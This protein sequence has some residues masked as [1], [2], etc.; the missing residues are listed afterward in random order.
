MLST[1]G[2]IPPDMDMSLDMDMDVEQD[3]V[4]MDDM[5]IEMNSSFRGSTS[6]QTVGGGEVEGGSPAPPYH[7]LEMG[8][9]AAKPPSDEGG[10]SRIRVDIEK[11][12]R[13]I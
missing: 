4:E 13:T 12:T 9:K 1:L 2:S 10:V 7:S 3:V 6:T 11:T 5:H 8:F